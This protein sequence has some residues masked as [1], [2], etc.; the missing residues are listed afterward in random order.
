M[1]NGNNKIWFKISNFATTSTID[2]KHL[3]GF[4]F[5]FIQQD[6]NADNELHE[7]L[8]LKTS[9]SHCLGWCRVAGMCGGTKVLLE[10]NRETITAAVSK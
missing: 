5:C 1:M 3:F 9:S 2:S 7:V 10:L 6:V 8:V 4:V